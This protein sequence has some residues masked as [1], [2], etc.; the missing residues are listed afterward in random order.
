ME[1]WGREDDECVE[2]GKTT[3][4]A[5]E[6]WITNQLFDKDQQMDMWSTV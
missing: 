4:R 1:F 3:K 5:I 2:R 6:K